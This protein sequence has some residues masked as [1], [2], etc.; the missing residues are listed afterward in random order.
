MTYNSY[1]ELFRLI[2]K[3]NEE[4]YYPAIENIIYIEEAT[5]ENYIIYVIELRNALSHLARLHTHLDIFKDK[6]KILQDLIRYSGHLEKL[7]IET[8]RKIN[9]L[10]LKEL[11]NILKNADYTR[12]STQIAI[13]T[14]KLRLGKNDENDKTLKGYQDIR[15]YIE[16]ILIEKRN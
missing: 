13:E 8:T 2:G 10:Y 1:P 11:K 6:E 12:V 14:K 4:Y 5:N 7:A 16:G 9:H 3:I 15:D